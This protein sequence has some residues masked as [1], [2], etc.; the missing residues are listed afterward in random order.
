MNAGCTP[1]TTSTAPS[2]DGVGFYQVT[3]Q[4]R[5][6]LVGRR[7]L[8][9]A[10]RRARPNLTVADR[11]AGHR[12]RASR[13]AARSGSGTC[14]AASRTCRAGRGR[15]HPLRRRGQQPAAAD[16]VGIGPGR[17][18]ARARH[19]R[20]RRQPGRRR[21]PAGPPDRR[22][23]LVDTQGH[24]GLA[25]LASP[26]N[27]VA[28]AAHR[29]GRSPPTSPRPAA[30]AR[31]DPALPAPDIQWHVAAGAV[32]RRRSGRPDR[33]R[34]SVLV[35]LVDVAQPRPDRGCAAPTRGTSR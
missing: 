3:Q 22:R 5:P 1:T 24:D 9:A 30:S 21:E 12:G 11:R 10:G 23:D 14:T 2:Q 26:R 31:T 18:P 27:L 29:P 35:T 8:P 19:R 33:P 17:P 4:G 20:R 15:G 32:P 6:A 13:A 25:E 34:V 28:L 16:A 7:R